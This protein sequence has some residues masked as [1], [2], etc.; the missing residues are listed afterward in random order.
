M[1]FFC[2]DSTAIPILCWPEALGCIVFVEIVVG[3]EECWLRCWCFIC[4][5]WKGFVIRR[6]WAIEDLSFFIRL[7]PF[8]SIRALS[9]L[10]REL[11]VLPP[12][13]A[14]APS[15]IFLHWRVYSQQ[16]SSSCFLLNETF[17]VDHLISADN[18]SP[19]H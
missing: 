19:C 5:E 18:A 8:W 1:F 4:W 11:S 17:L 13:F 10:F 14:Q 3:C 2:C 16:L 9:W 7:R 12:V 15:F 6:V